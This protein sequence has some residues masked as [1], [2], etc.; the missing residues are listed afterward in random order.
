VVKDSQTPGERLLALIRPSGRATEPQVET[1]ASAPVAPQAAVEAGEASGTPLVLE[2]EFDP[3][4]ASQAEVVIGPAEVPLG[5]PEAAL[6][7]VPDEVRGTGLF[8]TME[9]LDGSEPDVASEP[10]ANPS[11]SDDTSAE[12]ERKGL[13]SRLPAGM[14]RVKSAAGPVKAR[15]RRRLS[16]GGKVH[17][18]VDISRTQLVCVKTRGQD[19]DSEILGTAVVSL[20]E[21]AEP[22]TPVFVDIL[23]DT[24]NGLCGSG[25]AP[26]VWAASQTARVNVQ[27]VSIPKVAS[28]QVDNAVFWTAKKE[29]GFDEG[30]VVFDFERR[31]EVSEKGAER[32]GALAYTAEREGMRSIRESF[33]RAGYPL[34]G[35]TTEPFAHQNLFRR[36]MM[37]KTGGATA[38]LYVGQNWSRLEIGAGGNLIFVRV[39]KTSM[40][41][42]EQAVLDALESQGIPG[43]VAAAP[44]G[45]SVPPSAQAK[46]ETAEESVVDLDDLG[47]SGSNLVLELDTPLEPVAPVASSPTPRNAADPAQ[48]RELLR[49]LVY[50]CDDLGEDHPGRGL[51]EADIMAML[52]PAASRLVRQVEMTLKHFRESLGF[53]GVTRLAVSGLLGASKHFIDYIGEQ[54]ALPCVALDPVGDYLAQGRQVPDIAGPGVLYAQA[55]GLAL[56]D[57]SITPNILFTYRDKAAGRSARALEQWTLVALAAVLA[58]LAFFSLD[59][60]WTRQHLAAEYEAGV[61]QLAQLGGKPN[62]ALLTAKMAEVQNLR[63]ATRTYVDRARILG[64][65][66]EVLALAP[67]GVGPG[68]LTAEFGPPEVPAKDQGKGKPAKKTVANTSRLVLEGMITGD[69]RLFDSK[70]ASYVVALEHS[71]LFETVSVSKSELEALDGGA[72][73]LHFVIAISLAENEPHENR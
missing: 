30:T 22:G 59:A 35:L 53:E 62:P 68:T 4:P 7:G 1:E 10:A 23:R 34:T 15:A 57:A 65:W 3:V 32:L 55:L 14:A 70:L 24:L 58:G 47:F 44:L 51:G 73:G 54:L 18:G 27:F 37:P 67:E 21:A 5:A 56:S 49:C 50:G 2:L 28:R 40:A 46:A 63:K 31:G 26:R 69:G 43:T 12:A 36:R 17:V 42:M 9:P 45:A 33:A 66:G 25:P 48:A 39:I 8:A 29:M 61:R 38:V 20:P 41:G 71:S 6:A 64:V 52:E 11:G 16:L 19:A 13:F 60:L 72:S